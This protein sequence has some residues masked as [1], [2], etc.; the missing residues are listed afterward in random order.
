MT[1]RALRA[2]LTLMAILS[3]VAGAADKRLLASQQQGTVGATGAFPAM[4]RRREPGVSDLPRLGSPPHSKPGQRGMIHSAREVCAP[5]VLEMAIRAT[6]DAPM[7]HRGLALEQS[8]IVCVAG[9]ALAG[10]DAH[11][12]RMTSAAGAIQRRMRLRQGA[13]VCRPF[14]KVDDVIV[15]DIPACRRARE[16]DGDRRQRGQSQEAGDAQDAR[17]THLNPKYVPVQM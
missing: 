7:K 9:Y 14:P 16:Q 13:G 2:E 1:G 15:P 4:E 3:L 8:A 17:H 12:R 6:F 10:V 11:D 5:E